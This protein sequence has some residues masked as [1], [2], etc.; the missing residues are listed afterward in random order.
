MAG[1][2]LKITNKRSAASKY[3]HSQASNKQPIPGVPKSIQSAQPIS[4]K[5]QSM[6]DSHQ[7]DNNWHI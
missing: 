3:S 6:E 2:D 1:A 7:V 5:I 4:H